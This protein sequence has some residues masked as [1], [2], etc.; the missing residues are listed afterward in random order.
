M[1]FFRNNQL[2]IHTLYMYNQIS[3]KDLFE[4]FKLLHDKNYSHG[5]CTD[6]TLKYFVEWT[7]DD[8]V[9]EIR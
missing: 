3:Q 9:T 2:V 1:I 4:D 5:P 8:I 7:E 6:K